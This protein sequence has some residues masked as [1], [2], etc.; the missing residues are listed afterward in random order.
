MT[1]TGVGV[2]AKH[3]TD[4]MSRVVAWPINNAGYVNLHY[5]IPNLRQPTEKDI[6][7]GKPFQTLSDFVRFA[8]WAV[9]TNNIKDIWFC[10]SLQSGVGK[11]SKGKPKAQ[12]L[13]GN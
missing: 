5:S 6:V 9:T 1:D 3:V 8:L 4:F 11:N 13:H 12:R 2:L 10:T 7:T